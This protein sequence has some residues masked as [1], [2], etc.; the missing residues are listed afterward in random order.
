MRKNT[1]KCKITLDIL[2]YIVYNHNQKGALNVP[3]LKGVIQMSVND[4]EIRIE[5]MQEWEALA[6]EAKAEEE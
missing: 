6:E 5:K 3:K 2:H 1:I 4:L